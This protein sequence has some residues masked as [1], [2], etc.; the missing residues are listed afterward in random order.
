M[1]GSQIATDVLSRPPAEA[2]WR[3]LADGIAPRYRFLGTDW[4]RAWAEHLLP[5]E[6]WRGPLRYVVAA[7]ADGRLSGAIPLATQSQFGIPVASLGGLYW[8]FRAPLIAEAG[9]EATCAA[10]AEAM[11]RSHLPV[12]LRYGPVPGDDAGVACLNASLVDR[13]WRLHRAMV[14]T[15]YAVDLP[16]TWADLERRIGKGLRTDIHYCE[17]KLAREGTLD[18][19]CVAGAGSPGWRTAID[20]MGAIERRSWQFRERGNLRFHGERNAAFWSR[21]LVDGGFG[22][23]AVAWL[24]RFDGEPLSFCFCL[25][26]GEVRYILANNYAESVSRYSTGSVLYKHVFRQAIES[27]AVRRVNIG[28]GDPGYKSRWGAQPAF[29]LVDWIAF[30]P[31]PRGA[32]LDL[33]WRLHRAIG[34]RRATG[35]GER[36]AGAMASSADPGTSAHARRTPG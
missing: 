19:R 10:L 7:H 14:G 27:G 13:G 20:D 3:A 24:M 26:C 11:T 15:T 36:G 31:G 1:N 16:G 22:E 8:P 33:A 4:F 32:A 5:Y 23:V 21:L 17:R 28:P 34:A 35:S 29:D 6:A 9:A 25:D 18:I 2:A 12:A 30:R